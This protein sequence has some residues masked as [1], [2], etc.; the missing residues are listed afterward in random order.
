MTS[1]R[2]GVVFDIVFDLSAFC[3]SKADDSA[4]IGAINEGDEI[5]AVTSG[6]QAR[7]AH[8]VV[9][10]PAID[11]NEGLVPGSAREPATRVG[12]DEPGSNDLWPDRSRCAR[13]TCSY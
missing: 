11:P 6:D 7:H 13:I 5:K 12:R 9:L 3:K 2:L 10:K 8:L 4:H 1:A